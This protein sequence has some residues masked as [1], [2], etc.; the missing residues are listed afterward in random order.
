[1]FNGITQNYLPATSQFRTAVLSIPRYGLH[2]DPSDHLDP[3]PLP[4][5]FPATSNQYLLPRA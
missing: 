2:P 3:L 1:M 4:A 5:I